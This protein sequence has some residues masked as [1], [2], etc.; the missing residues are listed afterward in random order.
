MKFYIIKILFQCILVS[1]EDEEATF[2]EPSKRGRFLQKFPTT[3]QLIISLILFFKL[4]ELYIYIYIG[5]LTY[6][7]YMYLEN[8]DEINVGVLLFLTHWMDPQT[9]TVVFP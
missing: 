7:T 4:L 8:V 2:V 1:E 5:N 3:V 9:L 6:I